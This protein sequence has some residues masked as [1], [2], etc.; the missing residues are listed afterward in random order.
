M[1]SPASATASASA[2]AAK[3]ETDALDSEL[4]SLL[5]TPITSMRSLFGALPSPP[6][7]DLVVAPPPEPAPARAEEQAD[8]PEPEPAEEK[9]VDALRVAALEARVAELEA[10]LLAFEARFVEVEQTQAARF[11]AAVVDAARA[12]KS[13]LDGTLQ[14]V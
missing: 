5:S 2:A 14:D 7:H 11:Q 4:N 10:R 13:H 3:A 9:D 1:A 8:A 12:V 6:Q